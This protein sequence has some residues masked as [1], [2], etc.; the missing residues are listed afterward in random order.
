ME[1]YAHLLFVFC[2]CLGFFLGGFLVDLDHGGSIKDKF[3]CFLHPDCPQMENLHRGVLHKPIV[4]FSIISFLTCL[5]I[6]YS[7][8]IFAD[9]IHLL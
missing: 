2:G 4:V 8:H 7:I 5:T 6:G 1:A 9:Y 3:D